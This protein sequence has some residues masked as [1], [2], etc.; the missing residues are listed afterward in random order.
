MAYVQ[1]NSTLQLFKGIN[2]DNRYLHT[3]YFA[4]ESAQDTW[5]SSKVTSGLTFNNLMYRRYTSKAV[6]IEIDATKLY[7]V[8]Y[9]R[10]KNTR[11]SSKWY[12]AFV[13]DID[14]INENTSV[15]YYEIDVMQTWFIQNGSVRPCMVMRE[16]VNDDT[17]GINLEEEPIGSNVYDVDELTYT[18]VDESISTLFGSY[19]L[20]TNTN[21]NP[22]D[23]NIQTP[24]INNN[25]VN[26]TVW[27][28][29][30]ES[31][32]PQGLVTYEL[33]VKVFLDTLITLMNGSWEQGNKPIEVVDMFT[34]PE[35]FSDIDADNNR[36]IVEIT[37]PTTLDGYTPKNKKLYSYP[38]SYLQLTTKNGDGCSYKWEYFDGMLETGNDA[39][40]T[41]YGCPIAGGQVQCYPRDYNGIVE[42]VDSGLVMD[43]FPKNPFTYDAYQAWV[44]GGGSNKL[45]QDS[46]IA[47][48][49]GIL[50]IVS[51]SSSFVSNTASGIS[52]IANKPDDES[53]TQQF[54][55]IT[56]G[57]NRIAQSGVGLVESAVSMKEALNKI[58]YAWKDAAYQPNIVVGKSTPNLAVASRYLD[59]YFQSVHVRKDELTRID[60]F[61]SCYGYAIKKVK[62]PN[63]TGRQY[64]NFIQTQNAVIAGDMPAS[65]KEAIGRIF[66]GGITFWHN[67]DQIGNYEQSVSSG[68]IN[69]PIV[70]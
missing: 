3:I 33:A 15:V 57:V 51:A 67:G 8:T 46:E 52:Q 12:Y 61:F 1:P 31:D 19:A 6:K 60:D 43:N 25:I 10:F 58:D 42:N 45:K 70:T 50:G 62:T 53:G 37:H 27:R 35:A 22:A 34:F 13:L 20:V 30:K 16:H 4:S 54:A 24:V 66:D 59:F 23:P 29:L 41:A 39:E 55:R 17:F 28:T 7:G 64:W 21:Q 68:S 14:Y 40:F 11:T 63:I 38:Y 5:F 32:Y 49:R 2:L 65:S 9:M 36:H 44:A 69:N 26:G 48:V 47:K 56:G 18:V